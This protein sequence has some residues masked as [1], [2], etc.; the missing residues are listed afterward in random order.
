MTMI[1]AINHTLKSHMDRM[2][3]SIA[4]ETLIFAANRIES[5]TS[6]LC[7][8]TTSWALAPLGHTCDCN[9]V[10]AAALIL[11]GHAQTLHAAYYC[12]GC[13]Q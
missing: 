13:Q 7:T 8:C 10:L 1:D 5:D 2:A 12:P 11:D 3:T 6:P 4:S 9:A